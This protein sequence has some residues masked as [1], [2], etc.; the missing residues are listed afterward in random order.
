MG[1]TSAGKRLSAA[2]PPLPTGVFPAQPSR[3]ELQLS[4]AP[5]KRAGPSLRLANRGSKRRQR[6][7]ALSSFTCKH[8]LASSS[9]VDR[10]RLVGCLQKRPRAIMG[11]RPGFIIARFRFARERS[12]LPFPL[13]LPTLDPTLRVLLNAEIKAIPADTS[14]QNSHSAIGQLCFL[15]WQRLLQERAFQDRASFSQGTRFARVSQ[16][17]SC[18][19][20]A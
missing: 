18:S 13:L 7:A 14:L 4:T 16:L 5:E 19:G 9:R 6:V 11:D 15:R 2:R 12:D 17:N 1:T 10:T 8:L 20:L 3:Q